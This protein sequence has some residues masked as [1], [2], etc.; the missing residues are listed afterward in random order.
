MQDLAPPEKIDMEESWIGMRWK[1][2]RA[3]SI[4]MFFQD[5]RATLTALTSLRDTKV[6]RV[7]R[8]APP[9]EEMGED[10]EEGGEAGTCRPENAL[11]PLRFLR[12]V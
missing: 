7:I 12:S 1:Y 6:G 3:P 8:L 9:E 5:D 11:F 4:R 10:R 2:P